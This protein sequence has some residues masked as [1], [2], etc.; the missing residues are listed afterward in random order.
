[1]AFMSTM[2]A[3]R[4][5]G[6]N[7]AD[8]GIKG[9]ATSS[10]GN[11]A[12][13]LARVIKCYNCQEVGHMARQCTKPMRPRNSTWFK[14]KMLLPTIIHNAD[15]QADDLDAYD[16]D[17]DD[18][19]SIKAV[20]MANLSSYGLDVLFEVPQHDTYQND[21]MLNQSVQETQYFKQFLIDYVPDNEITSDSNIISYEQYLQQTQNVIVQDTNSSAQQ[22]FSNPISEQPVVQTTPVRTE[23]PSE[24][25]KLSMVKTSFQKLKN[26]LASFDKVVKVRTTPDAIMEG[27]WGFKHT[28]AVF[29]QEVIPFIKT[30]RDLFK[31]FDNGLH[32]EINEVKIVFNQME[33]A[34]EH[35]SVDKKYFDNQK[36]EFFL[37]NDR[38]LEHIICQDVTNIVTHADFV[39][40]NVLPANNKC[41]VNDNLEIERLDD[42]LFE[43]LLS[44][45]I[46]HICVNSLATR[47]KCSRLENRNVN[48]KLKLQYQKESVLNNRSFNNQNALDIPEFFKI[49]EWQ[50][51]L[52]AKDVLIAKLRKHIES[53]KGKNVVE[54]DPTPNK[55]KVITPGMFKLNLEPLSPK[56]LKNRDADILWELVEHARALRPLD[57][58]LD[59]ACKYAKRIK[60]VLVYVTATCPRMKSSTSSSRSQPSGNTKNNRIS[61]TTSSN[62]KNIVEDHY[63]SVKCNSNKMNHVNEPIR[64]V[65]VKHTMLNANSELICVK[66]NQCMFDANHDVCFLKFVNDVNVRSKSKSSKRS[67]KKTTWKPTSKVFTI[68]GYKWIPTGQ[69]FTIDGNRCPLTRIAYTNAVPSKNPLPTKVAKKTTPRRNKPEM[70]KDVTNISSS[71]RSKVV[72][73]NI[74]NNPK[75]SQ[76]WGS[77]V[78]TAPSSSFIY[79]RLSKLFSGCP[80][81]SMVFELWTLQAYERKPPLA[82]Q[83]C[84]QI[85]SE[86]LGKLKPKADIRIFVGYAPAKKAY[87][88]YNKRTRLIIKTIHVTFD[89]LTVM[90]S[91]QFSSEPGPQLLTLRTLSSGVYFN[92]PPSVALT[93]P[94][95]VAPEPADST[96]TP[97]STTIDQDES[98]LSTS[99]TPQE[100]QPPIIPSDVEEE[101]HDI[102]V[103]HL[104]N[105]PFFG[106]PILEPN[107]EES[108]SMDVIPTNVHSVN[109]PPEHLRK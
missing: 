102:K 80:N 56:V 71:S 107:Y 51:K 77:N 29:K 18:I 73:S 54:N 101:F 53:M 30:L 15:F 96:G 85:S 39:F 79:F 104:D 26:H 24:L 91:K 72:E 86:D 67:K 65:N 82:H 7:F 92:P 78:S 40:I 21:N 68:V 28:K 63:R 98:S 35:C 33:A 99:Q 66:C 109:Q 57:S 97:S 84:S 95:V 93:V 3:S 76:N 11:N 62:Q 31:D 12:A 19:S 52:D 59:L 70:L 108:S 25:P 60:E 41:L 90:V 103:A 16:S 20:L 8:T 1:M 10:G 58:D 61:Q 42:H 88:I 14:E 50:A 48:L 49:N 87:K 100:T 106:V 44:H 74:S 9:N 4:R 47:N 46:V 36:K 37:D 83:L 94:T 105:F 34:V 23:A 17:C 13:G 81:C 64:N 5:Q 89:E 22:D 38:L 2:M 43:L 69:K 75:P 55:A 27:S 32:S 45:N 6:Q